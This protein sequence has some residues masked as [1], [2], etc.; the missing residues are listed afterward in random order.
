M[1]NSEE[2]PARLSVK[3]V[4]IVLLIAAS[5]R[6]LWGYLYW[7][8][9]PTAGL[10]QNDAW[11]HFQLARDAY[12]AETWRTGD[13]PFYQPPFYAYWLLLLHH[14]GIHDPTSVLF[15]QGFLGLAWGILTLWLARQVLPSKWA[16]IAAIL[17]AATG[18]PILYENT[19]LPTATAA[20]FHLSG[21]TC[22]VRWWKCG[23]TRW[24]VFGGVLSGLACI[25]RPHF[26]AAALLQGFW[27]LYVVIKK[28]PRS[29][30]RIA[31][32]V[33]VYAFFAGLGPTSTFLYNV[34][35][36]GDKV[37][38]CANGGVT[39]CM[40]TGPAAVGYLAPVTDL[41]VEIEN[42]RTE[43]V[44]LAS[45]GA[46]RPLSPSE[47]SAWWYRRGVSWVIHHPAKAALLYVRKLLLMGNLRSAGVDTSY[48][49]EVSCVP[50]LFLFKIPVAI[51]LLLGIV[52]VLTI[53]RMDR[54]VFLLLLTSILTYAAV[55]LLFYVSERFRTA[56]LPA[57]AVVG[58]TWL[59]GVYRSEV[60]RWRSIL[61]FCVASVLVFAPA[62]WWLGM[63]RGTLDRTFHSLAWYN[64]GAVAERNHRIEQAEEDYRR[65]LEINPRLGIAHKNLG[66]LLAKTGRPNEAQAHM[67]R[68]CELLP[69]D[70]EARRNL[71]V[72]LQSS[73]I[74]INKR[75]SVY[76][77]QIFLYPLAE[78]T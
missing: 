23:R 4:G 15:I 39:F 11:S 29:W 21:I 7:N 53:H 12:L 78:S 1:T 10:L 17:V 25:T 46:G 58:V 63:P 77:N 66:V 43:S 16:V 57:L 30:K 35:V 42:Q 62:E 60:S 56:A 13:G 37:L 3:E 31:V 5:A 67:R 6:L 49:F 51:L 32:P 75:D 76:E 41:A 72:L 64:L 70:P 69:G 68:A 59:R 2:V 40:G 20:F 50:E 8:G 22:L 9:S 55:S 47:A 38:I 33:A 34:V 24:L 19:L 54:S 52:A 61:A 48:S 73:Q 28:E 27:L 74:M 71:E 36:G 44:R 26:L 65:A 45:E 18:P 14:V